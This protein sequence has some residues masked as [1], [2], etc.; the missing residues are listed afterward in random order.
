MSNTTQKNGEA[1]ILTQ[2]VAQLPLIEE[3]AQFMH[4]RQFDN[5]KEMLAFSV[6][7]LLKMEGFGYRCLKNLY[8]VLED[9]GCEDLLRQE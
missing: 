8:Q 3:L 9:N 1:P 5:L 7:D 4:H 2:P 6:S